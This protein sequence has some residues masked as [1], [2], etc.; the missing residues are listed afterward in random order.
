MGALSSGVTGLKAHQTMLD[1][2]GNNLANLNTI[3]FK[4]STV[5]FSEL[6]SQTVKSA[7]GPTGTL[8]GTNPQ[9][10]GSGVGI[11]NIS[12]DMGQGN[13]IST[14]QDLDVAIDGEGYFVLNNGT[15][16][17]Y[18]R[19][20]SFAVDSGNTLIDPSNGYKVQRTGTYGESDNFQT[21]GDSS[22]HIPWDTSMPAKTTSSVT[23]NG[24]LRSMAA[25]TEASVNKLTSNL[26]LTINSGAAVATLGTVIDGG[27]LDQWSGTIA[28][29][30]PTIDIVGVNKAGTA[31]NSSVTVTSGMTITT[32]LTSISALF[33]GSTMTID[34]NGKMVLTDDAAGYSESA[35]TDMTYN[36]SGT[37]DDAFTMPG[38][39]DLTQ[40]GGNDI[41]TFNTTIYDALGTE[42]TLTGKFIKTDTTNTWDLVVPAITGELAGT[43]A[44]YDFVNEAGG[45]NRRIS[46]IQ[47][48]ADGSYDGLSSP[49][50]SLTFGVQFVSGTTQSI[51]IDLGAVGEFSGVT[52]F[53][54]TQSSAGV[55]S[56]DGYAA[57]LLSSMSIDNSG[58]IIGTFTNGVKKDIA[59]LKIGKFQNPGG[60]EAVDAGY[61]VESANSGIVQET[62]AS[63][64]G[65]GT[66]T[67]KS[68]ERSNVDVA[69]QFVNMM[70]AQNGF[71]SNARTIRIAND[72]LR[73]LTN[74]IR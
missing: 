25:A 38:F 69:S 52:Q 49:S 32:L 41:K 13:I 20:G 4:S 24:N 50:E 70:Q 65:A 44:S 35:I 68:L 36:Q 37:G 9:Q 43:W 64:N 58:I 22:I 23:L 8:G 61:Y 15:T 71:Q 40:P 57:G 11:A 39:F 34:E 73:E 19:I 47:F 53:D 42:H 2:A 6:L 46:G 16:N 51:A 33:S 31:V 45:F 30:D 67:N 55:S 72:I 18:T 5:T 29:A 62:M 54:G 59:A 27:T 17:V 56:Q 3:G 10:V 26:P 12:R 1:I 74:L 28:G 48:A 7:S 14:G 63:A 66:I 60:L 21:T